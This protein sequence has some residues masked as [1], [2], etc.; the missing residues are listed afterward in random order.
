MARSS[1]TSAPQA[2]IVVL[3][4]VNLSGDAEQQYLADVLT[5]NL[6]TGFAQ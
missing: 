2:S 1:P 4:F 3:P 6:T 5:E